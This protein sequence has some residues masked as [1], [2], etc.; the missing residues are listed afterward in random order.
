MILR[1]DMNIGFNKNLKT[2]KGGVY[3][4][5]GAKRPYNQLI[6]NILFNFFNCITERTPK[7]DAVI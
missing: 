7:A 5:V 3:V 2:S 4:K 1:Q 6:H